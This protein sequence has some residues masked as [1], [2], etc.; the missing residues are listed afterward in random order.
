MSYLPKSTSQSTPSNPTGTSSTAAQVM[1]GLAGSITPKA[2]GKLT[3]IISGNITNSTAADGG[4][5]QIRYGTGTAP[6][7]GATATG[8]IAGGTPSLTATV[9]N[10]D[11]IPFSCQAIVTGLTVG[12]TY[13]VDLGL[14]A[15]TGGTTSVANIS[16]SIQEDD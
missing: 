4:K 5:C 10:S 3:I 6:T 14:A 11:T 1:M 2:T 8:T 16:I 15:N 9:G 7:N 12:T 13:W